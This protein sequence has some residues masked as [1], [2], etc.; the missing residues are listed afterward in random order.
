MRA[1]SAEHVLSQASDFP[2]R[3]NARHG[4]RA[5]VVIAVLVLLAI[6]AWMRASAADVEHAGSVE[7][8]AERALVLDAGE[9]VAANDSIRSTIDSPVDAPIATPAVEVDSIARESIDVLVLDALT[10]QPVAGAEVRWAHAAEMGMPANPREYGVYSDPGRIDLRVEPPLARERSRLATTDENGIARVDTRIF[11]GRVSALIGERSGSTDV[12]DRISSP[13]RVYVTEQR[14]IPI[15]VVDEVGRPVSGVPVSLRQ[16]PRVDKTSMLWSGTTDERGLVRADLAKP[17]KPDSEGWDVHACLEIPLLE[18]VSAPVDL[19]RPIDTAV[20]LVLPPCGSVVV[21]V[22]EEGGRAPAR[23]HVSLRCPPSGY[24]GDENAL[25]WSEPGFRPDSVRD[26]EARYPFVGLGLDVWAST[27]RTNDIAQASRDGPRAAG[28]LVRIDLEFA[29]RE[30]EIVGRL[31]VDSRTPLRDRLVQIVY[32]TTQRSDFRY[33]VLT[34]ADGRFRFHASVPQG[35]GANGSLLAMPIGVGP[36]EGAAVWIHID[37]ESPSIPHDVGDLVLRPRR[38]VA[39]GR[40]VDDL[41]APVPWP[42]VSALVPDPWSTL[43]DHK[44]RSHDLVRSVPHADGTFDVLASTDVE[45]LRVH[46]SAPRHAGSEGIA[47]DVD[48][49]DVRLVTPRAC[50][51]RGRVLADDMVEETGLRVLAIGPLPRTQKRVP[52]QDR[53]TRGSFRI[54]PVAP[55]RYDLEFVHGKDETPVHR[56][57]GIDVAPAGKATDARLDAIDLRGMVALPGRR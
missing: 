46:A 53:V 34:D 7:P 5:A 19:R 45:R 37:V 26:G 14:A 32:A 49:R 10:F 57:E 48:G 9:R 51:I 31:L 56:I 41:G 22:R 6:V 38:V 11:P 33:P 15:E 35:P 29:G 24:R 2:R 23:P 16:S 54:E 20:R 40:V 52:P 50:E 3:S 30:P 27:S 13:I 42:R 18:P 47:I 28:E 39:S 8:K 4:R 1:E 55:G 17:R 44:W 21:G 25:L 12:G 43:D 36:G